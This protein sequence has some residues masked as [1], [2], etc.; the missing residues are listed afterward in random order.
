MLE[1]GVSTYARID[2]NKSVEESY[3]LSQSILNS[4]KL[5][6]KEQ[7]DEKFYIRSRTKSSFLKNSW[8]TDFR[9]LARPWRNNSVIEIYSNITTITGGADPSFII[10]PF[11]HTL[12]QLISDQPKMDVGVIEIKTDGILELAG[13]PIN[14]NNASDGA[15][16]IADEIAKLS[17]LKAD[18]A[19]S[20]EEFQKMKNDLIEKM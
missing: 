4:L 12:S 11:Y 14:D 20:E 17:K 5:K 19:L 10:D 7:D 18:G 13:T 2:L 3:R 16:S 9:I 15:I 1:I 8:G 6:V